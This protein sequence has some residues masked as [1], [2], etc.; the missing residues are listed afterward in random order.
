M[1]S[2]TR[3]RPRGV[4]VAAGLAASAL[5]LAACGG[6]GT[7]RPASPRVGAPAAPLTIGT[8]DKI[9]KL[10]PAGSYDNGSFAV[11]NQVY[12]VPAE[13]P[14]RQPGR[15]SPTSPSRRRSP[16]RPSTRSS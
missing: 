1:L 13:H 5:V 8:T 12:P 2:F 10:D 16:R 14:V 11:M 6:G 3:R 15:R 7:P 4:A 9:T